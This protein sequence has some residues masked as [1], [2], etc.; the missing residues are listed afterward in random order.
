MLTGEA[1]MRKAEEIYN[2]VLKK[3]IFSNI[4]PVNNEIIWL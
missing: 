2:Q 4:N 1:A 3:I